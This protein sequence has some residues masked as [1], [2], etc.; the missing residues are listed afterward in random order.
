MSEPQRPGA[1]ARELLTA[2]VTNGLAPVRAPLIA[3]LTRVLAD[4]T[5]EPA[6]IG[7][8]LICQATL[9]GIA[10]AAAATEAG[11]SVEEALQTVLLTAA[12]PVQP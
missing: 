11:V 5:A 6:L 1:L 8:L 9:G 4:I 12:Q 7:D 10:I 3:T 2:V